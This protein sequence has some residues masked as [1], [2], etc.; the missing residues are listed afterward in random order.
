[1]LRRLSEP[2]AFTGDLGSGTQVTR[3]ATPQI[4]MGE[5]DK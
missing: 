3:K 1:V 5:S 2:A 4:A